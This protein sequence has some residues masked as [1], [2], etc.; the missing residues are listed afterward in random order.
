[1]NEISEKIL[2]LLS[3]GFEFGYRH[4]RGSKWRTLEDLSIEWQKIGEKKLQEGI[5][6][7]YRLDIIDKQEDIDGWI[8]VRPTEKGK[9][10][11][12]NLKLDG[13]KYKKQ[14]W[15]G[16]WR[17]VAFDIPEKQRR[18]RNALRQRL[19]KIGF[20]ELQK[21]ILI[22]PFDCRQEIMQLVKFFRI[23]KYVRLGELDFIDNKEHFKKVFKLP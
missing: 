2:L 6:N 12:L 14:A 16:K 4:R 8:M 17:M 3:G 20:C 19:R 11:A 21:S 15:D 9:L 23:E 7:L 13:I 10:R 5:R 22:T 1:M 18:G